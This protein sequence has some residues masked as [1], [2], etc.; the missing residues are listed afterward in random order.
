MVE[1]VER[2]ESE[3]DQQ[4]VWV[5]LAAPYTNGFGGEVTGEMVPLRDVVQALVSDY[6]WTFTPPRLVKP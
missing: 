4:K 1:R 3:R 2:L 5:R 6:H